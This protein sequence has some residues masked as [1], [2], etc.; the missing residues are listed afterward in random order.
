MRFVTLAL[1]LTL[2][3]PAAFAAL[4]PPDNPLAGTWKL[5]PAKSHFEG[6]TFTLS[7]R[8]SGM[9]H[10]SNGSTDEYD[11]AA[12]GKPYPAHFDQT[13]MVTGHDPDHWEEVVKSAGGNVMQTNHYAIA[14]DEKTMTITTTGQ[15]P[16]G[17]SMNDVA[18]YTRVSGTK[19]GM[20]KWKSTKVSTN[21][22]GLSLISFPSAD[23]LKWEIP[24][25]KETFLG[26]VDGTDMPINGPDVGKSVT[27]AVKRVSDHKMTYVVKIGGKPVEM[28]VF[29]VAPDGK[30]ATDEAWSPGK[31]AEKTTG[32]YVKQ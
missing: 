14:P 22:P 23:T 5:D 28:G 11:F 9:L 7:S 13:I 10:Y 15:R 6:D 8:P 24:D 32:V 26:K 31:E 3:V 29:T 2:A 20:G 1:A 19:G 4:N 27:L 17:S 12:D 25:Y 21:E 18:T 16:D 30:M